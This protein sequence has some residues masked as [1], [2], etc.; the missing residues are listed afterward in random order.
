DALRTR[1][2][3]GDESHVMEAVRA[4]ELADVWQ[5]LQANDGGYL[6]RRTD[7]EAASTLANAGYEVRDGL[8]APLRGDRGMLG[9]MIVANRRGD[10]STF[11]DAD[12]RLVETLARPAGVA[13]E[14]GRLGESLNQL[15]ELKEQLRYQAYHDSLTGLANRALFLERV[16]EACDSNRRGGPIV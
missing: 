7:S 1:L 2:G 16:G 15:T 12:V 4:I 13:L 3:P 6:I 11:D 9:L 10:V 5:R 8:V 14:N